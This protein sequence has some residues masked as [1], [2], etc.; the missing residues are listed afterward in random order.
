MNE[1]IQSTPLHFDK[2]MFFVDLVKHG[3]QKLYIEITQNLNGKS[4][5]I[6]LNPN[7]ITEVFEVVSSYQKFINGPDKSGFNYLS[8][9]DQIKLKRRYLKGIPMDDLS[10]QFSQ[11][12]KVL[13]EILR[14]H[15]LEIVSHKPPKKIYYKYKSRENPSGRYWTETDDGQLRVLLSKGYSIKELA[16]C[17]ERTYGA[18]R[19]RIKKLELEEKYR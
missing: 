17:F 14:S 1:T 5:T 8:D 9:I 12:R 15:G 13:E 6:K 11:P 7:V 19:S 3:N 18:I 2:S 16:D 10:M 4:N